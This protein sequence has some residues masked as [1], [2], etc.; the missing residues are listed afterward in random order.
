MNTEHRESINTV[1]W[2][3]SA[4]NRDAM[5]WRAGCCRLDSAFLHC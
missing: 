1:R 3:L 2:K 4:Y 5:G